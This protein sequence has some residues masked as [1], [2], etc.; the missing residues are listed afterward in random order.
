M[1]QVLYEDSEL[2][3]MWWLREN[4]QKKH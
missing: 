2:F 1:L 3:L 4:S